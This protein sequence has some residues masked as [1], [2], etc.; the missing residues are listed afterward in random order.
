MNIDVVLCP[1]DFS[2]A[3]ARAIGY[4]RALARLG[5]AK[6]IG[7]HVEEP[8]LVAT[9]AGTRRDAAA[10]RVADIDVEV[11][12]GKPADVIAQY[13]PFCAADVIVIGTR[14]ASGFRHFLLGSVTEDV[15]R[16]SVVPVLSIPPNAALEPH[17]PFNRMLFATDL[18]AASLAAMSAALRLA[19]DTTSMTMLHVIDD[20]DENELFVA[21]PYD[22]H[23][24]AAER[25]ANLRDSLDGI[26]R[27]KFAGR[28]APDVRIVRGHTAH[29]ILSV[30]SELGADL[31]VMGVHGRNALD[32]AIFGSTTNQVVRR[33]SCP[34]LT[35]RC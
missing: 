30:A 32:T 5:S 23:H 22:V 7:L 4:A 6:L 1:T 24:H 21:R 8:A 20:P 17:L 11:A 10:R 27:N 2:D 25:E 29:Q 3:S 31:L 16:Q 26:V 13:A 33:A 34:V 28:T 18:S 14:G 12:A 15:I 9:A 19:H 35:A